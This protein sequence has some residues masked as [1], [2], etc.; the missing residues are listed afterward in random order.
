[1]HSNP[2]FAV[3]N[4][5]SACRPPVWMMRQAGRVLPRYRDLTKTHPFR[6]IMA[7]AKLAAEVTLMP[8]D[9]MGMDA[10]ILFSD[11]LVI[12]EALGVQVEWT[13]EGPAFPRPLLGI[14]HPIAELNLNLSHLDHVADI[15]DEIQYQKKANTPV[16]GFCGGPLTCLC[17]MLGGRDKSLQFTDVVRY[18]YTHREESLQL[19]EAL[20]C[21]SEAYVH[22]QAKHGINTFQIFESFAYVVPA[23]L[24]QSMVLPFVR[25]IT[26]AARQHG[27][28]VIFFPKGFGAGLQMLTPED[29]DFVSIDWQTSLS[30]ARTLVDPKLG[31]Q[32]NMDPRILFAPQPI[33]EEKL[34]DYLEFFRKHPNYIFNL[35]HGLH[36]DTPLENVKFVTEWFKHMQ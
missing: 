7:D 14:E 3:I 25:R 28:P 27:L 22:L 17:Y 34:N 30:T 18:L 31:L 21:A 19:L 29:C 23:E 32:G 15:L 5:Q 1:M 13:N 6:S 33:I 4:H 9:D 12:P 36:K 20:T 35:G 24:Y 16:I 8:I 26:A 11:I 2:F 10:A